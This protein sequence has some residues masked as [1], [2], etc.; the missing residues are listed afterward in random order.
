MN[1]D[2]GG[3][4]VI[5][6]VEHYA[7]EAQHQLNKKDAY[8]KLQYDPTQI[9]TRLV[10]DK[11]THFK[12]GKLI[13]GNIATGL[14]VQQPETPKFYT[15]PKIHKTGNPGPPVVN[16]LNCH[17][18]TTSK[19]ADFHLQPIVTNIPSYVRNTTDFLQ[20]KKLSK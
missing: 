3:A 12:N 20:D 18:N 15:R 6:A 19:Y 5:I 7:K 4:A 2:K 17:T 14:Q 11:T 9:H 16:S 10:N 13:T 8:K 1:T